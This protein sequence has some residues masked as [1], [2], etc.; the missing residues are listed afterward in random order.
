[1]KDSSKFNHGSVPVAV[2]VIKAWFVRFLPESRKI[3]RIDQ[4]SDRSVDGRG[5]KRCVRWEGMWWMKVWLPWETEEIT[6]CYQFKQRR[7][8]APNWEMDFFTQLKLNKN[9]QMLLLLPNP[10]FWVCL[11]LLVAHSCDWS[12]QS[13]RESGANWIVVIFGTKGPQRAWRR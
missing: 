11:N 7:D 9:D 1:M 13:E 8:T 5:K 6:D 10:W 3:W 12:F 4:C 2:G